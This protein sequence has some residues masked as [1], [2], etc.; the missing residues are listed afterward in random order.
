MRHIA[1][2]E[3]FS[4]GVAEMDRQHQQLLA[5]INRL[6][7]TNP[8]EPDVSDALLAEMK[9]YASHHFQAEEQLLAAHDYP[10]Q[11]EQEAQHLAFADRIAAFATA[12]D[13]DER[14]RRTALLDYLSIW[15]VNHILKEDMRYREFLQAKGLH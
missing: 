11:R 2:E 14:H 12:T 5:A 6:L 13:L 8:A 3:R 1:W 7:A 10:R 9:T 4:V 15:L